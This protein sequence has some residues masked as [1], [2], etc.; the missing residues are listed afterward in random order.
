MEALWKVAGNPKNG[1]Q[2]PL[3]IIYINWI[4]LSVRLS[5][6]W[7][8]DP[9]CSSVEVLKP[10]SHLFVCR[11]PKTQIPSVRLSRSWN[12]CPS[13]EVLKPRSRLSVCWGLETHVHLS[14]S[15]NPYPVCPFVEV[16]KPMSICRGI[17]THV[18]LSKS[19]NPD[20]VCPSVEVLK[21]RSQIEIPNRFQNRQGLKKCPLELEGPKPIQDLNHTLLL[22]YL[23]SPESQVPTPRLQITYWGAYGQR[24]ER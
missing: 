19:W 14:R 3:Q 17:E 6:S 13:V 23:L 24:A 1:G 10:R 4:S 8:P 15:W 9:V 7:N 2:W 22:I 16:L 20:P 11:G 21:P 5:R 18:H 12:P